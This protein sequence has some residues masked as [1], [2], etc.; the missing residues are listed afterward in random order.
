MQFLMGLVLGVIMLFGSF[1][2]ATPASAE[3]C[4]SATLTDI[5]TLGLGPAH[6]QYRYS[7]SYNDMLT[8]QGTG[9]STLYLPTAGIFPIRKYISDLFPNTTYY[10]RLSV[11]NYFGTYPTPSHSNIKSFTTAS[12]DQPVQTC[13]DTSAINYHGTLPCR[14]PTPTCQ[15][16]TATNYG[17]ALPCAYPIQVCQDTSAINYHGTLPCRYQNYNQ[18]PT[19]TLRADDTNIDFDDDTTLRWS[20][21]NAT[22]CDGSGGTNDWSDDNIGTHGTFNTGSL[23]RDETYRITCRNSSGDTDTDSVTVRVDDDDN[24]DND[25]EPDVTTRN[26]TSIGISNATLNG[27]ADGNGSSVRAWFEYGTNTNLEFST[28]KGSHGSGTTNYSKS[29]SGLYANT[30]YYFRA[31][32]E[33]SQ[34]T[35]YG[36]TFTFRTKTG[37]VVVNDQPTVVIYAD[38]VSLPFNTATSIRWS[39]TNATS[40]FASGGSIGWAGTKNIGS[41][42]FFTGLLTGAR[43]Y[44][45]TCSNNLG[46]ST[47]SVTVSVHGQITTT[48]TSTPRPA[49]TSLVL[50]NSSVNRNQPIASAIDN[51]RPHPG[52]EIN[53]TVSYQNV[54]TASI[55]SLTLRTDLPYEV[56]YIFSSPNSP[57]R[58]GNTLIFNLGTLQANGQDMVTVRVRVRENISA[59][60]NLNFP[61]TLSYINP[62]GAPQSVTTNVFAQIWDEEASADEKENTSL[63]ANVF[64]A[65]FLP[66]NIFG[67]ILL[68]ILILLLMLVAKYLFGFDQSFPFRRQTITTADHHSGKKNTTIAKE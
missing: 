34:D 14:Y 40:C 54:G 48:T 7:T 52:D 23:D 60:T 25:D 57:I 47:D 49:P 58:S 30:T 9:T 38:Q 32:A 21:N 17:G 42:S 16:T 62:A 22:R 27:R 24:N 15:D 55:T 33:N 41:G 19:V 43:T 12:C 5:I 61:A 45:I 31:V 4:D 3:S 53:Y 26:A 37:S 29:I 10:Y 59:G 8:G 11:T 67:W 6:A 68:A 64:G 56:D 63:G 36:D 20:S 28:S 1:S 13:Q 18:P 2:L 44:T 66:T 65:G 51:T 46:S 39:T 50:I 35:V